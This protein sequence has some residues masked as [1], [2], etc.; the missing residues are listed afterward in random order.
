MENLRDDLACG[1]N[2]HMIAHRAVVWSPSEYYAL[3]GGEKFMNAI[4]AFK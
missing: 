1:M 3:I 2:G 4:I